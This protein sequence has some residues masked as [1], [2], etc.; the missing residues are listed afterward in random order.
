M[1]ICLDPTVSVSVYS[2]LIN[3]L[4]FI[5]IVLSYI[6]VVSMESYVFLLK[7]P[8]SFIICESGHLSCLFL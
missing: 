2:V 1:P 5:P 8:P 6:F 3:R 7:P 4:V